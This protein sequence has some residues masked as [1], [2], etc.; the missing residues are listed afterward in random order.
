[1][2]SIFSLDYDI[3]KFNEG[4][5]R[6]L[7]PMTIVG[8]RGIGLIQEEIVTITGVYLYDDDGMKIGRARLFN[9]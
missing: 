9:Q 2:I 4:Y 8:D 3:H 7:Q 1:M 6:K 5:W